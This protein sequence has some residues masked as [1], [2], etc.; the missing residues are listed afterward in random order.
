MKKS[1][2]LVLSI[3]LC[4]ASAARAVDVQSGKTNVDLDFDTLQSAAGLTLSSVTGTVTAEPGFAV[5]FPINSRSASAPLL[6]TTFSYDPGL[7]SF[8]G[9]IEHAGSVLFNSDAIEVGN[10]TI[11]F[12]GG[13]VGGTNSGFFVE[14]TVGVAGILFDVQAPS[15]L[16][17]SVN[18]LTIGADLAV[19]PEFADI[20]INAN[21]TTSDLTGAVVGSALV[22]A[23]PEPASALTLL[24][25][26]AF[27]AFTR[28]R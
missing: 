5:A 3:S 2:L 25:G 14:S 18:E 19:S 6:P 28:R 8:S 24:C 21:L 26:A 23:V 10:F 16:V 17:A 1:A 27:L 20:L 4:F 9:T 12:D 15:T 22:Q 7:A 13:R 11:G